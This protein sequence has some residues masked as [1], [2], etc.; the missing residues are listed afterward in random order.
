MSKIKSVP[1][2]ILIAMLIVLTPF[3]ASFIAKAEEGTSAQQNA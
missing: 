2:I 1:S 3:N